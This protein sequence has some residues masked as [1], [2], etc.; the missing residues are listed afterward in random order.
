[1]MS[2]LVTKVIGACRFKRALKSNVESHAQQRP[3][4][5]WLANPAAAILLPITKFGSASLLE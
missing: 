2:S 4:G 3:V 5:H 1:M